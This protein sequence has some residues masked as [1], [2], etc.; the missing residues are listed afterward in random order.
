MTQP[1]K[2]FPLLRFLAAGLGV[3]LVGLVSN[4]SAA[5]AAKKAFDIPAGDAAATL[6]QFTAQAGEQL[7]YTMDAVKGV[8]SNAVKGEM[9]PRQA[10]DQMFAGTRLTVV[11]D[12]SNGALSVVRASDPNG[13]R[14]AQAP[15][16]AARPNRPSNDRDNNNGSASADPRETVELTPFVINEDQDTGYVATAS[17]AGS[18]LNTSLRDTA[19]SLSVLTSEFISDIGATSLEEAMAWSTNSQMQMQDNMTLASAADDVNSTFFNFA[20]FRVRGLPATNTRNYFGWDLPIDTYN[21]ERVEEARGP[22]S[23]LFGIGSAGGVVNTMTKRAQIGRNFRSATIG[24]SSFGGY[25]GTVDVNQRVGSR[26]ALRLNA[27]YDRTESSR[28]FVFSQK[29]LAALAATFKLTSKTVLRGEYETGRIRD[30]VATNQQ[31][32]DQ[33]GNWVRGGRTLITTPIATTQHTAFGVSRNA[34]TTRMTLIGNSDT[35]VNMANQYT[36]NGDDFALEP[37]FVPYRVS[38]VGPGT[39]RQ[40]HFDTVNLAL[41]HQF[42]RNTFVELAYAHQQYNT[43]NMQLAGGRLFADPNANL[44]TGQP[45][46]NAGRYYFEAESWAWDYALRSDNT[47]LS[48]AHELDVGKWGKY[49]LAALGEYEWRSPRTTQLFEVWDGAPYNAS[50]ENAANVV[51]RRQYVTLGDWD[52]FHLENP[53]AFG[54]A[55]GLTD[56]SGRTLNSVWIP[57]NQNQVRDNPQKQRSILLATQARYFKER[58]VL[59]LGYRQDKLDTVT[60]PGRRVAGLFQPDY[61]TNTFASYEGK[62]KTLGAVYHLTRNL[63]VFYNWSNNF[64][65]PPTIFLVPDGRR[66]SNPEGQGQDYGISASLFDGKLVARAN[67]YKTD[68]VNGANSNY[69]GSSTAP[70]ALGDSILDA[71]AAQGFITT[72][73]ANSRK[74][75]NT[76]ATFAQRV[77]GYEFN[78]TANPSKN[79]R[80]QANF[81]YTDGFVSDVAPEVQAW[82]AT[83]IP[84]FKGFPQGTAVGNSTI[85]G[86][87]RDWEEYNNGQLELIGLTLPGNRKYK[88]NLFATYSFSDGWIKGLRVGGGYKHQSKLPIGQYADKSLQYGPSLTDTNFMLGYRF[89]R[90]PVEFIKRLN[91]QL[92]V[93]NALDADDA[94]VFR[95]SKTT[96]ER[97]QRIRV[98]EGRTWRMTA[99]F[100]F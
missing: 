61:A 62:T 22:N 4:A 69:G 54:L 9:S 67:Y 72:A 25:R 98:R 28:N 49:R 73:D 92:N 23:I 17:L 7:L 63:S 88:V 21:T 94:Y 68:L 27:V 34:A 85:G 66:A 11:Q 26:L 1:P 16:N 55:R 93:L 38:A 47:R 24:A 56:P 58:L 96:P 48:I 44:P 79:W 89:A 12:R 99:S 5:T 90:S 6:K 46:P 32:T 2:R 3:L 14:A 15:T 13:E 95:R 19:A 81:S 59:G 70:D 8:A 80:V 87:V 30:N 10:L 74:V 40:P 100:D 42:G 77:E 65:L 91:L 41:D 78:L 57:R 31:A 53:S 33:H 36:S 45:N 51:Y 83:M 82:A 20:A 86:L 37:G 50:P 43:L 52:N 64:G 71:L 39:L 75:T 60:R 97:I 18:R 35:V 76:G 84:Y 29:Q